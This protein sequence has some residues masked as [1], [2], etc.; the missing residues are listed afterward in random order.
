MHRHTRRSIRTAMVTTAAFAM[1][2][3]TASACGGDAK[4]AS[5]PGTGATQY[6]LR[7]GFIS[8][9]KNW[10]GP[11]G[12][13]ADKGKLRSILASAGATSLE[14][15]AFPNGPNLNQALQAGKL[16]IGLYGDTPALVGRAAG[17]DTR[18]VAQSSVGTDAWIV[19]KAGGPATVADLAGKSV[20][21]AQGS[22]MDRYL[23][24]VLEAKGLTDKVK[25]INIV[26]PSDQKAA[27]DRGDIAA[28][29]GTVASALILQKAGY[30]V[31]DKA[32]VDHPNLR[33]TGV[34]II[35]GTAL[36]AH[37]DLPAAWRKARQQAIADATASAEDYYA[38]QAKVQEIPADV[39]AVTSAL[40][41][42]PNPTITPEGRSL[43]DGTNA[44]LAAN[45]FAK[46]KVDLDAWLLP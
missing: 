1:V 40:A 42:Y 16:D 28:V 23:R 19:T 32:S 45:Q 41:L 26:P 34:T 5:T 29:A 21:V 10:T 35:T 27:L 38:V 31:I 43:L 36:K 37:P 44:F 15:T 39:A 11:E 17:L 4:A 9:N 8:T 24:G 12:Y 7:V 20:A 30:Q 46:Q 18:V 33:G 3:V 22:Y 13:S 25:L 6:T 2:M 14:L